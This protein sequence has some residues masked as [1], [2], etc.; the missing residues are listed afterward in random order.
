MAAQVDGARL[1][2]YLPATEASIA[3]ARRALDGIEAL[4]EWPEQRFALRL[5]VTEL[6]TNGVKYGARGEGSRIRLCVDVHD[7]RVRVEVGDR[8]R[9]FSPRDTNWPDGDATSGRGLAFLD[10]LADRWGVVRTGEHLVWLEIDLPE[11][12]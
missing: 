7:G 6:F 9:G 5:L 12:G 1:E 10:A 8:G 11:Q 3:Q 4:E 2:L